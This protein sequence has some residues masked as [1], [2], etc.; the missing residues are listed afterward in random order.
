[1]RYVVAPQRL[2]WSDHLVALVA[3]SEVA[4]HRLARADADRVAALAAASRPESARRTVRLDASPLEDD[5]ADAVDARMAAGEPPTAVAPA[6][7]TAEALRVGWARALQLDGLQTQE[8]AELEYANARIAAEA[9]PALARDL[10]DDPLGTLATAHGLL[11]NGLVDPD[12]VGRPRRTEQAMHDGAQ[13]LV[14]YTA[15]APEALPDLLA[16]LGRLLGGPSAALPAVVV[17]GIV[18]ERILEWL[19]YEAANGRLARA[20]ERLVLIARGVDVTGAAVPE[21]RLAA[22]PVGYYAEVAATIRRR[23][24]LGPWLER[25]AEAVVGA[26]EEAAALVDPRDAAPPPARALAAAE[27]LPDGASITAREHADRTGASRETALADLRALERAGLLR[28]EPGTRGLRWRR[29][30]GD[31]T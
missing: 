5:T 4:A 22:D 19:P 2:P 7:P 29:I 8:V 30:D 27:A 9:A 18:H 12:V 16:A 17:A 20:A 28:S 1:M 23:G 31:G 13:G 14:L 21:R 24:D 25:S 26:L 6:I 3:R 15:P 10:F 11:C